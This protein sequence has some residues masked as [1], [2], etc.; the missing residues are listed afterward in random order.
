MTVTRAC[1]GK[2]K[3]SSAALAE[4]HRQRLIRRGA[5]DATFETYPCKHCSTPT[6]PVWH[7]GHVKGRTRRNR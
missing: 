6:A 7:V 4:K 3:H 1:T 2:K 5:T